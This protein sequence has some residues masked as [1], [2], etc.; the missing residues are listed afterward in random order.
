M[1]YL[2]IAIAAA[3]IWLAGSTAQAQVVPGSGNRAKLKAHT[4]GDGV[5]VAREI[6]EETQWKVRTGPILDTWMYYVDA[7][8]KHVPAAFLDHLHDDVIVE[9]RADLVLADPA[10]GELA[11]CV[12]SQPER[13]ARHEPPARPGSARPSRYSRDPLSLVEARS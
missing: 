6:L 8:E 13:P 3:G 9:Q 2:L 7:A 1:R 4:V 5:G 11:R 12:A 10:G